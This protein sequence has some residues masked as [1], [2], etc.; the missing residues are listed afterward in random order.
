MRYPIQKST[1]IVVL[2]NDFLGVEDSKFLKGCQ[3][4]IEWLTQ[5]ALL[6]RGKILF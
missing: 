3:V 4:N 6:S 1:V 2:P 5:R